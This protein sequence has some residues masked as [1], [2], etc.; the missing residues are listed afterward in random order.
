MY[1]K[2]RNLNIISAVVCTLFALLGALYFQSNIMAIFATV[3]ALESLYNLYHNYINRDKSSEV[4]KDGLEKT[5]N[6]LNSI[7]GKE[8]KTNSKFKSYN[9]HPRK[10][11]RQ[12][13]N[14]N[15]RTRTRQY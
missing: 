14:G 7:D 3:L 6:E 2:I 13:I 10:K 11:S 8:S 9:P 15:I 4:V 1:K 5:I 12:R